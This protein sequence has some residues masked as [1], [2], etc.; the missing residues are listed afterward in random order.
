MKKHAK[1]HDNVFNFV[2]AECGRKFQRRCA[3]TVH[4][5]IHTGEQ[6]FKCRYCEKSFPHNTTLMVNLKIELIESRMK[7]DFFR[8]LKPFSKLF[9]THER[10][11]TNTRPHACTVCE[12]RSTSKGNLN[13]HMM[14]AHCKYHQ[15]V[16]EIVL[17]EK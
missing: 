10:A 15:I 12:Y 13:K 6:P 8:Q 9:Q 1:L 17:F 5:R 11:H 4:M 14:R 16:R 2:C 7:S 3:L